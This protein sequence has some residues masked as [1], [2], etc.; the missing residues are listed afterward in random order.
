MTGLAAV[1]IVTIVLM[2]GGNLVRLLLLVRRL[3]PRPT[4]T[5]DA[6]RGGAHGGAR[7]PGRPAR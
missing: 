4:A 5:L 3:D 6:G 2:I 7:V 1:L